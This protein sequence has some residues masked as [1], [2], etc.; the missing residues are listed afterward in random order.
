MKCVSSVELPL[1]LIVNYRHFYFLT[2][3]RLLS[4]CSSAHV[5]NTV[6]RAV[7][8]IASS[9]RFPS[10]GRGEVFV[11]VRELTRSISLHKNAGCLQ[12][13]LRAVRLLG[14][15]G[16]LREELKLCE[17][18][19][20]ITGSCLREELPIPV[21]SAALHALEQL[22]TDSSCSSP[23]LLSTLWSA[24]NEPVS[25]ISRFVQHSNHFLQQR[26]VSILC[27]CAQHS[28]GK[29]ALSRAGGIECLVKM[30]SSESPDE[31]MVAQVISS[32]C[33]CCRDVHS[34]QKLRD[35]GGLHILVDILRDEQLVALHSDVLSALVCYYFD[36][37]TLRYMV[38]CLGLLRSLVYQLASMAAKAKEK[39]SVSQESP[40][41]V[42][43]ETMSTPSSL[44]M[45]LA[46]VGSGL[47]L[48]EEGIASLGCSS[49]SS[50]IYSDF[51]SS[52]S[53]IPRQFDHSRSSSPKLLSA[54]CS[55]D[56]LSPSSPLPSDDDAP[57]SPP[58]LV[59]SITL[60]DTVMSEVAVGNL[61]PLSTSLSPLSTSLSPTYRHSFPLPDEASLQKLYSSMSSPPPSSSSFT[62]PKVQLDHTAN[63]M[64]TN[65][66]DSL[67]S[68]PT[69]YHHSHTPKEDTTFSITD[70]KNTANTKTLLLLSR[71]SHLRDCLPCLASSDTL[72]V[73]LDYF[74]ATGTTDIHCFKVLSRVF[75]N[76]HC[77][78][79]CVLNLAPSLLL[80][81]MCDTT[82]SAALQNTSTDSD[83]IFGYS[84][85][86]S[87][88]H[89]AVSEDTSAIFNMH[90]DSCQQLFG[91]LSHVAESPYG[92]GVI[93]H[94]MLRG[95]NKETTAGALSLTLLQK[96][97]TVRHF[98]GK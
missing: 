59:A 12:S 78:Q 87:P 7:G 24:G 34:R 85:P 2:V 50:P 39:T 44:V 3:G 28:D 20:T 49:R 1:N 70:P 95:D 41:V 38:R 29:A 55:S 84:S 56:D 57:S 88:P 42:A 16:A 37:N 51:S 80:E 77:F 47:C 63:Q 73:I 15:D 58:P 53:S 32:L 92:Q 46:E 45:E 89:S 33:L 83:M 54:A 48:G 98:C 25:L 8:N 97:V 68:S 4:N 35:C 72:P 40:G 18:L 82:T 14:S 27:E 86:C 94:L 30:L 19:T 69:Y 71:V 31:H 79:D 74:F 67:L 43:A 61:S 11:M 6:A 93:A 23:E 62:K 22:L 21:V 96:Y 60:S 9:G 17:T 75:S 90:Q 5:L 26:A 36:E 10:V 81:H 91:K 65:F 76:P 52:L 13:C 64:P 66:I